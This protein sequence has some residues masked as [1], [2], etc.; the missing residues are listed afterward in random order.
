MKFP[1]WSLDYLWKCVVSKCLEIS[2]FYFVFKLISS[3]ILILR[4]LYDFSSFQFV[5]LYFIVLDVVFLG[6]YFMGTWKQ[7][8]FHY[9]W[10]ECFINI[11]YTLLVG[12]WVLYLHWFYSICSINCWEKALKLPTLIVDL[13]ISPSSSINFASH[14]LDFCG[15]HI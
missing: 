3:S 2:L 6:I 9:G 11:N 8:V 14:I 1:L 10:M 12:C 13:S 15:I 4:T 5:E 7:W